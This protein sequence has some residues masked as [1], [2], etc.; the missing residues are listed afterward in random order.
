MRP[1]GHSMYARLHDFSLFDFH[2]N[3]S[4]CSVQLDAVS[5]LLD[6]RAKVD[7]FS[8]DGNNP[9]LMASYNGQLNMVMKLLEQVRIERCDLQMPSPL[10]EVFSTYRLD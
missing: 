5:V 7:V 2:T 1:R 4:T 8:R 9:L 3:S 6:K 10:Q